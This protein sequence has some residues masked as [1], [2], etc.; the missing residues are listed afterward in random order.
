M[1]QNVFNFCPDWNTVDSRFNEPRGEMENSSLYRK[2]S[3]LYF[4]QILN[5]RLDFYLKRNKSGK[6][7]EN[8]RFEYNDDLK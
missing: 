3:K 1:W 4:S 7:D 2:I 6:D 5:F 8:L